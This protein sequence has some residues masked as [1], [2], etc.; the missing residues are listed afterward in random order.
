MNKVLPLFLLVLTA[1]ACMLN[2]QMVK[3]E[4][5]LSEAQASPGIDGTTFQLI[6][7]D[8]R[9]SNI[10]GERTTE[11]DKTTP[12][13][14]KEDLSET[15]LAQLGSA[16]GDA[17]F[18][19]DDT[20]SKQLVVNIIALNYQGYGETRVSEIE[21][22]AE[23]HATA[24]SENGNFSKQYKAT[25]KQQVLKAPDNA[26]NEALINKVFGAVVQRVLD[27]KELLTYLQN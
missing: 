7:Q 3:I 13:T 19:I 15:I 27:D 14:S 11:D 8:L 5:Q 12:V 22:A 25:H 1:T 26:T 9:E 23:I 21:V 6:V 16:F 4:P 2:P 17:G 10:L 20:A 24:V 18:D